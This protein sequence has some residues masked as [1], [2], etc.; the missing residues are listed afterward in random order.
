VLGW[1]TVNALLGNYDWQ[2][3]MSALKTFSYDGRKGGPFDLSTVPGKIP[4]FGISVIRHGVSYDKTTIFEGY[5]AKRNWYPLVSDVYEEIIPSIGD[6]YPDPT[7]AL[8]LYMGAPTYA[9]PAG[10]T[11]IEIL[12]DTQKVPLF[13]ACDILVGAT[14][15]YADYIFPDLTYLE[16]WE[17]QGSHPNMNLQV[18]PVR[19]PVMAPIPENCSVFREQ[20]PIC[21]ESL[22]MALGEKLGIKAFGPNAFGPGQ[23]LNHLDAFYLR[24]V[25]NIAAGSKPGEAVADADARE[26]ELFE[27]SRRHLPPTVFDT[28][29]WK[30]IAGD[31][32]WAKVV[33][34]LNRGGRFQDPSA[35][36]KAAPQL[37]NPYGKL[38]CLYQEKTAKQRY[39]G[40]GKHYIGHTCYLPLADIMATLSPRSRR[41][42]ISI[43]LLIASSV[44]QRAARSATTG[45]ARFCQRTLSSLT[46]AMPISSVCRR[47]ILSKSSAQRTR[48]ANGTSAT[49]SANRWSVASISPKPSDPASSALRSASAT[50]LRDQAISLSMAR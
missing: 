14:S 16:R 31:A 4:A 37:P 15:K 49:A 9:L 41:G 22:L 1:Y 19:Q 21:M 39:A 35:M 44:P 36:K 6:A 10:H 5:P 50:G 30:A 7:K 34:V 3:G 17:F 13:I 29:R 43:S 23:D 47:A 11:N 38:L 45:C 26:L 24:A 28:A 32:N 18:Q 27:K 42:T 40:T 46:H 20:M 8:L 33:H 48:R 25:A 2:G 12:C